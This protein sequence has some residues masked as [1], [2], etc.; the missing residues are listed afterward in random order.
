MRRTVNFLGLLVLICVTQLVPARA[1]FQAGVEAYNRGDYVAALNELMPLAEA[2]DA[3]AQVLVGLMY[4][5]GGGVPQDFAEAAKWLRRS[6]E[7]GESAAQGILGMMYVK[8]EGVPRDLVKA[9]LCF[10]VA[11]AQGQEDGFKAR[12][13]LEK[14]MTPEDIATARRMA[15]EC[16]KKDYLGCEF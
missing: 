8:A 1:D 9:H 10:N 7:Q 12:N 15:S 16:A 6:A 11:G 5:I 3:E 13:G 2:G 4:K 14:L